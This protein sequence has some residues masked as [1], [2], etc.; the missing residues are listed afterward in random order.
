M[1]VGGYTIHYSFGK[2]ATPEDPAVEE[3]FYAYYSSGGVRHSLSIAQ[4]YH[5]YT[6]LESLQEIATEYFTMLLP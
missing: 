3:Q 4:L 2:R 1:Q 6:T 5:P